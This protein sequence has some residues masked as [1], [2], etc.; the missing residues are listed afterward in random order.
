M[1]V[2]GSVTPISFTAGPPSGKKWFISRI[3]VTVTDTSMTWQD[4]GGITALTNGMTLTYKSEGTTY[5]LLDGLPIKQ[6]S[7]WTQYCYDVE[8]MEGPGILDIVRVRWTFSNS[9]TFLVLNNANSDVFTSTVRD[10]LTALDE[11]RTVIQGYE[12]DE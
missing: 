11:Y 6:N 10:N 8:L 5:D 7:N 2:N 1:A 9:G 3:L 4:F 12:V